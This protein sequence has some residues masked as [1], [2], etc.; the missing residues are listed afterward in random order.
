MKIVSKLPLTVDN[1]IYSGECFLLELD[2]YPEELEQYCFQR[3]KALIG[4]QEYEVFV[5][6]SHYR[7]GDVEGDEL[8]VYL[9]SEE[10]SDIIDQELVFTE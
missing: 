8:S 4:Q 7:E 3:K 1:E 5:V 9:L 10:D 2:E 6:M